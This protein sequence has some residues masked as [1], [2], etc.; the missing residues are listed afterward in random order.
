MRKRSTEI[1]YRMRMLWTNMLVDSQPQVPDDVLHGRT[2]VL[3]FDHALGVARIVED[4]CASGQTGTGKS[5]ADW[6][7]R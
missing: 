4:V 6:R 5:A 1:E 3:A 2:V 7:T